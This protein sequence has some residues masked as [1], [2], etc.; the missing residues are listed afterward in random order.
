MTDDAE[1]ANPSGHV[2][3]VTDEPVLVVADQPGL[4]VV[5]VAET[6]VADVAETAVT[7]VAETAVT[8]VAELSGVC[9]LCSF[10]SLGVDRTGE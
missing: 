7:G 1:T 9:S 2:K 10:A 4:S 8:G 5:D 3:D 6:T